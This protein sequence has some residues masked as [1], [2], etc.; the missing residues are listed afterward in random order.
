MRTIGSKADTLGNAM[1]ITLNGK[2]YECDAE[3]TLYA[4]LEQSGYVNRKVAA[5]INRE[6]VPKSQHATY[7]LKPGDQVEIVHAIGGG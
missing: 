2:T 4:L 7:R 3:I 1:N 6:I 5:E